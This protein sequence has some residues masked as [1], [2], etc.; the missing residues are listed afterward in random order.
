MIAYTKKIEILAYYFLMVAIGLIIVAKIGT[1]A[2]LYVKDISPSP[3]QDP[4]EYRNLGLNTLA[5]NGFSIA[6]KPPYVPDLFRT[7]LYPLFLSATFSLDKNG[8]MAILLQQLMIIISVWLFFKLLHRYQF[9]VSRI[10]P[11][12]FSLFLLIEPRIWFWSLETMT[13]SLFIF[14]TSLAIFLLLY[15][16]MLGRT[17]IAGAAACFGC[18]LLTRPAGLLWIPGF[19]LFLLLYRQ[20]FKSKLIGIGIFAV[21]AGLVVSPWIV[22]NERLVGKPILSVAEPV[23]YILTF[24]K[25]RADPAWACESRITDSKGRQGCVFH[26]WTA[27][28]FHDTEET[29]KNLRATVPVFSFIKTNVLGMYHFWA[30]VDYKDSVGILHNAVAGAGKARSPAWA[31]FAKMSHQWYSV[32]LGFIAIMAVAGFVFLYK[33]REFAMMGLFGG[34]IFSSNFMNFGIASGRLHLIL[35]PSVVFLA[36]LGAAYMRHANFPRESSKKS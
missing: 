30:P 8:H 36:G 24:G 12:V 26:G 32:V 25:G 33:R 35:L 9:G 22:R 3:V 23:D 18:A 1:A 10:V 2:L 14:L 13:E 6:E 16:R 20:P 28:G 5:G 17:H 15:P 21:M 29:V 31:A 27:A 11:L 34:I 4:L 7:P 19:F